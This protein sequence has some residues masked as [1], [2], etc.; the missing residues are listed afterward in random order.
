M[1]FPGTTRENYR[2]RFTDKEIGLANSIRVAATRQDQNCFLPS[3]KCCS[4]A[5]RYA[6][7]RSHGAGN[8][9]KV[10]LATKL[11]LLFAGRLN[12]HELPAETP[13][14]AKIAV[15]HVVV[16][17]R[18]HAN[19][20]AVLLVHSEGAAHAAIR[21]DGVSLGLT[22]FVPC[23]GLAHVIFTL[24]HQRAGRADTDAV[25]AIDA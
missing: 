24:E 20:L 2:V 6:S 12:L 23:A 8:L 10:C 14:D 18:G 15:S 22:V 1:G 21:T 9:A 7:G 13:F 16:S 25:A 17:R 5:S 19:D 3:T 11:F 4:I